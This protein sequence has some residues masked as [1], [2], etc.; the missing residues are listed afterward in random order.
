MN[1]TIVFL[2]PNGYCN[3]NIS[4][5]SII[6]IIEC[7]CIINNGI[8]II[9]G[10]AAA[11]GL[12][13]ISI[14]NMKNPISTLGVSGFS[15]ETIGNEGIIEISNDI[16]VKVLQGS[17]LNITVAMVPS[18]V[19]ELSTYFLQM[20]CQGPIPQNSD[21]YISFP[22]ECELNE[23]AVIQGIFGVPDH[24]I[25]YLSSN[26]LNISNGIISNTTE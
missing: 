5:G 10:E 14:S 22:I 26:S 11:I 17:P 25:Y 23:N 18:Q 13:N 19:Y 16:L 7:N 8:N 1:N 3:S 20:H 6:N 15:I 12:Y 21:I 2:M 4:C 9:I 24:L